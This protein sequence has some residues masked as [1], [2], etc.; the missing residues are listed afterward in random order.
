MTYESFPNDKHNSRAVTLAEHEQIMARYGLSGLLHRGNGSAPV[1]ADSTGLHVKLRAGVAASILGTRFNALSETTIDISAN[2]SGKPRID[3]VVLRLRRTESDIGEKDAYTISPHV[4]EG[5]PDTIP[6]EPSPTR[7]LTPGSGYYDLPLAAT[8]V[9][10]GAVSIAPSQVRPRAWWISGSG[11]VGRDDW[12]RP[13]VEPGVTWEAT[14]TGAVW[15]GTASGQ[16]RRLWEDTGWT[17]GTV[18]TGWAAGIFEARRVGMVGEARLQLRRTG[19]DLGVHTD[20]RLGTMPA[21]ISP[22]RSR[23]YIGYSDAQNI[24]RIRIDADR[25]VWLVNHGGIK[26]NHTL[27]VASIMWLA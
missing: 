7:D 21:G 13:P 5:V 17:A 6:S 3:L 11:Y 12:G 16:W 26:K 4:I 14:D 19:N 23:W 25:S 8:D 1:Y 22:S 9:P 27:T 20:S 24:A 10:S 2:T 18:A 15:I